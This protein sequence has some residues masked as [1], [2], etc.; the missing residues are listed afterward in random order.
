MADK[1][2]LSAAAMAPWGAMFS[3]STTNVTSAR[4]FSSKRV[5][6][7]SK[8]ASSPFLMGLSIRDSSSI[9]G[10]V[11]LESIGDE[12]LRSSW[13]NGNSTRLPFT[14]C[15]SHQ[16]VSLNFI[17]TW[18]WLM[19]SRK[20]STKTTFPSF[21]NSVFKIFPHKRIL[22]LL[23]SSRYKVQNR[24]FLSLTVECQQSFSLLGLRLDCEVITNPSNRTS[25]IQKVIK[26]KRS[27]IFLAVALSS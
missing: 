10:S 3:P 19:P 14:Q 2:G 16:V 24:A 6:R 11:A 22:R 5:E 25:S 17:A 13:L 26:T 4:N 27:R 1:T 7:R 8:A 18:D 12:K 21:C 9:D 20:A 15:V 23:C